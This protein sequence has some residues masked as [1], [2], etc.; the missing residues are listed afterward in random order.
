MSFRPIT[1]YKPSFYFSS[2][3]LFHLPSSASSCT[4]PP[5][6]SDPLDTSQAPLCNVQCMFS[7]KSAYLSAC[8]CRAFVCDCPVSSGLLRVGQPSPG[9]RSLFPFYLPPPALPLDLTRT[10]CT[11]SIYHEYAC[12]WQWLRASTSESSIYTSL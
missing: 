7:L 5:S 11:Y 10:T 6:F 12:A 3:R 4:G 1:L 8:H 9:C 2:L